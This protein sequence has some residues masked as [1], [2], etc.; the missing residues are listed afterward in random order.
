MIYLYTGLP[1]AGKTLRAIWRGM[2]LKAEGRRVFALDVNGLDFAATGIELY[3]ASL[4]EW[5]TSLQPNDA[6]IVDEVQTYLPPANFRKV[7]PK[8]IEELTRNRHKGVDLIFIT[9]HPMNM[10]GFVRRL[11]TQH[12]HLISVFG[13][14]EA[15]VYRW[16]SCNED[17]DADSQKAKADKSK[18]PYPKEVFGYYKSAQLHTRKK[19]LPRKVYLMYAAIVFAVLALGFGAWKLSSMMHA[20]K[21][22]AV[23]A[24]AVVGPSAFASSQVASGKR[25]HLPDAEWLGQWKPRVEGVMWS[26]PGFDDR[27]VQS[28]PELYC[29]IGNDTGSCRCVTEQGTHA[30][31]S[32][33]ACR[34]YVK[35]GGIYNPFRRPP[36]EERRGDLKDTARPAQ[37]QADPPDRVDGAS[38]P[39][40]F[41]GFAGGFRK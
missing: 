6:L 14:P 41:Q 36:R 22:K 21:D 29:M 39:G 5:A 24:G 18:W 12:E 1:G 20:A 2:Q 10:D 35:N 32:L 16:E 3:D 19:S 26:S 7:L 34:S 4:E 25:S 27:K 11:V 9:Q 17:P 30:V 28:D 15:N 13:G 31:V 8:W 37:A 33:D 38:G 23:Q 40:A